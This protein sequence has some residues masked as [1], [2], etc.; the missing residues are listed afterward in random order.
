MTEE[1]KRIIKSFEYPFYYDDITLET[2]EE[3]RTY[4]FEHVNE[5]HQ[6]KYMPLYAQRSDEGRKYW[7][8]KWYG[9]EQD[10]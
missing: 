7:E 5:Y 1:E 4:F 3:E 10:V 8:R 2:F 6:G 9:K